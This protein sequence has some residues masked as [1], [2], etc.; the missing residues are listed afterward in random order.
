MAKVK[1]AKTT[2]IYVLPLKE[3]IEWHKALLP[4]HKEFEDVIGRDIIQSVYA[5]AA[6]V[7]KERAAKK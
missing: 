2:E 3:R 1:A 6:Q 4:V 5:T 7:E